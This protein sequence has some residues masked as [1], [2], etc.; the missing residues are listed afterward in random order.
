MLAKKVI[1]RKYLRFHKIVYFRK[2]FLEPF[3]ES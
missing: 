2:T 1:P 3:D